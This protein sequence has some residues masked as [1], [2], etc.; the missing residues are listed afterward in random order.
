M[1]KSPYIYADIKQ[2]RENLKLTQA[3]VAAQLNVSRLTFIKW[4]NHTETMPIGKYAELIN[5][6]ES[7]ERTSKEN[8]EVMTNTPANQ[9]I[10]N[11]LDE[12][13]YKHSDDVLDIYNMSSDN[14]EDVANRTKQ[15]I[16]QL[17]TEARVEEWNIIS[18]TM[19]SANITAELY[20]DK[21]RE[22]RL[23]EL[24]EGK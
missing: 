20:L 14:Y 13:L 15:A 19:H 1:S 12:I 9:S 4:E 17:I 3:W 6:Y 23:K 16:K 5:L 11:E 24:R 8:L 22:E 18:E 7:L 2:V 10:D 21:Q